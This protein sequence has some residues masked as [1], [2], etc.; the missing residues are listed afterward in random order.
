[1][2]TYKNVIFK[3]KWCVCKAEHPLES[4]SLIC[5]TGLARINFMV[6]GMKQVEAWLP[7]FAH[8]YIKHNKTSQT[9]N[10]PI[11]TVDDHTTIQP[12]PFAII[13]AFNPLLW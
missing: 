7:W 1:M 9:S 11:T 12:I 10:T 5:S 4:L 6:N 3:L 13:G 8:T 2:Q